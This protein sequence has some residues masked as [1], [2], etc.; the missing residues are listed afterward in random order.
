MSKE[1]NVIKYY[2]ICNKLK[3]IIRTGWI[4][5]NVKAKRLESVAEH[6]YGT[7]MLAIAILSEY[8]EYKDLNKMKI[9][10]MLAI[11]ELGETIIGDLTQFQITKEEKQKIEHEAVRNIL[12]NLLSGE[13]I[14]KLFIEFDEHKTKESKFAYMCDKL[15]CDI[16]SKLYEEYVDLNDQENNKT[17][18]NKEVQELLKENSWSTMWLKFG[19]NKYPYDENF[20]KIS[21]Y[22]IE[23]DV[24]G[25]QK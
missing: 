3:N 9:I 16:Q 12:Q 4:D 15:E 25:Y 7:Q 20:M 11:H 17:F 13:E 8:E 14:N 24:K 10:F 2:V 22:V 5:W 21:N 18:K 19:Q 23:N 1:E 6:I